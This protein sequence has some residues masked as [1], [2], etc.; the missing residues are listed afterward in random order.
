MSERAVEMRAV[1]E[2]WKR[3]GMS[4]SSFS[5][6]K[7]ISYYKMLYWRDKLAGQNIYNQPV[8]SFFLMFFLL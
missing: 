8:P 5:R 2:E 4:I 1:V 6:G 3:S 7:Y